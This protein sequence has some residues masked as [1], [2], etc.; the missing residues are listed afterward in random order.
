MGAETLIIVGTWTCLGWV[1]DAER[2]LACA[3]RAGARPW[4]L[5]S[6][7]ESARSALLWF[8][9]SLLDRSQV[10]EY[11]PRVLHRSVPTSSTRA[12]DP[13]HPAAATDNGQIGRAAWRG[14]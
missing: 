12:A 1:L 11:V 5:R 4:L 8:N 7:I 6:G 10:V 2:A 3:N 13:V 14:R 9:G